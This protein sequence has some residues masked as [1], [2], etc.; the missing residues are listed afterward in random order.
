MVFCWDFTRLDL[1]AGFLSIAELRFQ[2]VSWGSATDFELEFVTALIEEGVN[3]P[4]L[5]VTVDDAGGAVGQSLDQ[6]IVCRNITAKPPFLDVRSMTMTASDRILTTL[7]P[8]GFKHHLDLAI[9]TTECVR[10]NAFND[11]RFKKPP[12]MV[13]KFRNVSNSCFGEDRGGPTF[14]FRHGSSVPSTVN[15][16]AKEPQLLKILQHFL[17]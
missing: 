8:F 16:G 3:P 13:G 6:L 14:N 2:G 15:D 11:F 5:T 7:K 9:E 1:P 17:F 12:V 10:P 4:K